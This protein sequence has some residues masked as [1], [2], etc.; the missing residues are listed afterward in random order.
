MGGAGWY[1]WANRAA[2]DPVVRVREVLAPNTEIRA[3]FG[4]ESYQLSSDGR[5]FAGA[6]K[7]AASPPAYMLAVIDLEEKKVAWRLDWPSADDLPEEGWH[8]PTFSPQLDYAV[9]PTVGAAV[10][11]KSGEILFFV[12][13]VGCWRSA[14]GAALKVTWKGPSVVE[15]SCTMEQKTGW[16]LLDLDT[17]KASLRFPAEGRAGA[18]QAQE[19]PIEK[20]SSDRLLQVYQRSWKAA[21]ES[22]ALGNLRK[23]GES[24]MTYAA[25]YPSQG[26]PSTLADMGPPPS[27]AQ[28]GERAA[29]LID[30]ALAAGAKTRYTFAYSISREA[31][32]GPVTGFLLVASPA[33]ERAGSRTFCVNQ[34]GIIRHVRSGQ[35]NPFW[36]AAVNTPPITAPAAAEQGGAEDLASETAATVRNLL[37]QAETRF[38][39]SDYR[40]ALAACDEALRLD[41]ENSQ[42]QALK[43][44][45][46]E[47]MR[48]LGVEPGSSPTADSASGSLGRA[49]IIAN[50]SS[51]VGSVRTVNTAEVTYSSTYPNVGFTCSLRV[52]GYGAGREANEA[53]AKLI[54]ESLSNGQKNGYRFRLQNC[55]GNPK[56]T[57]QFMAEP[58]TPGVTGERAFCSDQSGVIRFTVDGSGASCLARGQ[59]LM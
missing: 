41:P 40:G 42:A 17:R 56:V 24:A 47:T 27:G 51:A 10:K 50:E 54:D 36:S 18:E 12:P 23:L 57:Y 26:F 19:M 5:F 20:I 13:L 4:E 6:V 48:I 25:R 22:A 14:P 1:F 30:A 21:N 58:I 37:Q 34:N 53:G 38:Q 49:Q 32:G 28:A 7:P 29:G 9:F 2:P 35:C 11:I 44:K 46:V 8:K 43:G 45:V 31:E 39:Q 33:D 55:Q 3:A 59:P 52:L 15:L 16:L